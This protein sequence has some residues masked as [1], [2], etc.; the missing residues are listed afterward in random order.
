[1][2]FYWIGQL[3]NHPK[4]LRRLRV[5][6]MRAPRFL[7]FWL[8]TLLGQAVYIGD[9]RSRERIIRNM[10]ELL[11]DLDNKA[12]RKM[13][14]RYLIHEALTIYEQAIEYRRALR[15]G[16]GKDQARFHYDGIEHLDGVLKL[17]RGAIIY[18]PHTGNY[19]Y[20]YWSLSQRYNCMTVATAGSKELRML[21]AG[22]YWS[23]LRG[24]DYDNTPPLDLIRGLRAHLRDNGVLFILGDFWRPEFPDCTLLG[25]PSKAPGGA[26][27]L[28]LLLQVPVIPFYG[29]R[30]GWYDHRLVFQ[31]PV[32]L[33]E[34]YAA[35][36]KSEALEELA[37]IMEQLICRAPEQWLFWFN[38]HE[39]WE[40]AAA[41]ASAK[42]SS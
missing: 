8:V 23:G 21:F 17:G 4:L 25:K 30:E 36:Q 6:T 12:L 3:V 11:P 19:F 16:E 7:S 28:S 2:I 14:R 37:R 40:A 1:M 26:M 32:H 18:T 41:K 5:W 42:E 13:C 31:P 22:F 33:Y 15:R 24:F 10:Q 9:R 35:D 39:R 27:I 29:V 34:K 38:V 20:H